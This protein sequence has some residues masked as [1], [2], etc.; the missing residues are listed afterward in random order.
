MIKKKTEIINLEKVKYWLRWFKQK[1]FPANFS[2]NT[3]FKGKIINKAKIL[4]NN[5][6]HDSCISVKK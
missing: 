5:K 1:E 4:D 3:P 6:D 2:F